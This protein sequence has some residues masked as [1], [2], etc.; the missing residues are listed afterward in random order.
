ML[1]SKMRTAVLQTTLLYLASEILSIYLDIN[2]INSIQ[3]DPAVQNLMTLLA[4]NSTYPSPPSMAPSYVSN[5]ELTLW[6][7]FLPRTAVVA[8][9]VSAMQYYWLVWLDRI[10]PARSRRRD[11]GGRLD[12]EGENDVYEEKIVK[13]WIA[14]GRVK[15]ASLSWWNTFLKWVLEM[16][17]GRLWYH[18]I[19]H[20]LFT[21]LKLQHP[22]NI[23]LEMSNVSRSWGD[24]VLVPEVVD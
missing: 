4:D 19:E 20:A 6:G 15:R 1:P 23:M 22:R 24:L 18:A 21:L 16:T 5:E 2:M 11:V 12:E 17:V 10:L 13:R 14:Q 3:E 7:W 8:A 9:I